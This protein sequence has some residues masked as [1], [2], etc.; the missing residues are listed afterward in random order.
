MTAPGDE[1]EPPPV[2]LQ[3][4]PV[5]LG[6]VWVLVASRRQFAALAWPAALAVLLA[7]LVHVH[8]FGA[9]AA[10]GAAWVAVLPPLIVLA[11]AWH[12]VILLGVRAPKLRWRRRHTVY[13]GV[14]L[15]VAA[16][17]VLLYAV[18]VVAIAGMPMHT[19]ARL[20]SLL[21]TLWFTITL[22]TPLTLKLPACATG[23]S[24]P[25]RAWQSRPAHFGNAA[26]VWLGVVPPG[27]V[28]AGLAGLLI[29][30]TGA[31][32]AVHLAA[33]V[34]GAA[35]VPLAAVLPVTAVSL[36]FRALRTAPG[37]GG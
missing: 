18:F 5:L 34:A 11:V 23:L 37:A 22:F 21:V 4:G 3:P 20:A 27:A 19:G 1:E 14:A 12:R 30:P 26:L 6:T 31:P 24:L 32:L 28:L 16:L 8:A 2:R 29:A 7:A 13:T 36:M 33:S 25:D 9:V 10:A 17:H 15:G 35:L